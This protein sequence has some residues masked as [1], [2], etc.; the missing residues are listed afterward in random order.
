MY[1][2]ACQGDTCGNGN[3]FSPN[4]ILASDEGVWSDLRACRVTPG[5]DPSETEYSPQATWAPLTIE[6]S[7]LLAENRST[8]LR[9]SSP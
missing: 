2:C 6:K 4:L 3:K 7:H 1:D 9:A 5:N 8:T